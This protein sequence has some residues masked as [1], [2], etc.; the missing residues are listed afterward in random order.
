MVEAKGITFALFRLTGYAEVFAGLFIAFKFQRIACYYKSTGGASVHRS[1]TK[2]KF[3]FAIGRKFNQ[4]FP[5]SSEY[6][7]M[8]RSQLGSVA[9]LW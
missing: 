9:I 4:V 8:L 7:M 6:S 3:K 2:E 5:E 1:I